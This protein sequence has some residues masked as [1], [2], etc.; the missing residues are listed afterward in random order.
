MTVG[1]DT[2]PHQFEVCQIINSSIPN[3]KL[4]EVVGGHM[5]ILTNNQ[6]ILSLL[7]KWLE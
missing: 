6:E 4:K 3:I 7:T 1:S 5:G 2:P